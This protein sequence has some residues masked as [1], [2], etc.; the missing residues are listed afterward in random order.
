MIS[1]KSQVS[2]IN[3]YLN[4][5]KIVIIQKHSIQTQQYNDVNLHRI[6][7]YMIK[8]LILNYM[9]KSLGCLLQPFNSK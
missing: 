8:S 5:T 1:N 4:D 2:Y 3:T 9:I 7:N 6:L